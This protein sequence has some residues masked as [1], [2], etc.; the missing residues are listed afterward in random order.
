MSHPLPSL[1]DLFRGFAR[2]GLSGFGG[3]LPFARRTV[4]EE[5]R[6]LT[7]KE[8]NGLLGLCQFLPGPNVVN[9]SVCVGA[10]FHGAA[11]AVVAPLGLIGAPFVLI[12]LL[13]LA[14]DQWGH[15]PLVQDMLRGV[16]AA[17]VGLLFS[18]AI[19]MAKNLHEPRVYLP[20]SAIIVVAI[21]ILRL[22]LPPVMLSLLAVSASLAAWRAARRG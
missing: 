21:L 13:A 17:G 7:P 3:V 19:K 4:V 1:G 10:R 14:Y 2:I 6:W 5:R 8:F 20:F 16:A 11:G 9:L 18:M 22:P 12:L 15:L